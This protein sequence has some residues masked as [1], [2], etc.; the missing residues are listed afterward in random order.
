MGTGDR[1]QQETKYYRDNM[2]GGFRG[3]EREGPYK[4][5]NSPLK[6]IALPEP[7]TS[8]GVGLWDLLASRRSVR[9]YAN[10]Q[11]PLVQLS[12]LLWAANGITARGR[13]FEFRSAP[14]AGALYPVETYFAANRVEDIE[15]GI[16]HFDVFNRQLDMLR[17]GYF[18]REVAEAAL[19]QMMCDR[20]AVTFIW[21]CIPARAKWKYA[22]RAYRYIY[23]DAGH[24][25]ENL[26]LAA[27]ALDLGCCMIGAFFDDELNSILGVDGVRETSIY[28]A[29]VGPGQ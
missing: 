15:P 3:G 19:G 24:L 4:Q 29:A 16:Y 18:G 21:T 12:Q 28:M 10:R 14:S 7:E 8:G 13:G 5:Y 27:C 1:Y 17:E 11:L 9:R 6:R 23:T 25:G 2:G 22:E 26:H 20:A